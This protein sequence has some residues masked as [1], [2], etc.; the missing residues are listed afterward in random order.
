MTAERPIVLIQPD[1]FEIPSESDWDFSREKNEFPSNEIEIPSESEEKERYAYHFS[2]FTSPLLKGSQDKLV[3][4]RSKTIRK[5][6]SFSPGKAFF[7]AV[8]RYI[9]SYV[10]LCHTPETG[11]WMGGTPEILLSGEKG[12]WQTV[13][14]AG[15]QSLRDG[16]LPKSWDHKNW[17]E[18]QLVASYIRRQLSTLGITPE[19]KGPYSARAGE[20]SHLKSDFFFSLPNPEKLVMS[21][22][23]YT[24]LQPFAVFPRRRLIISSSR[25][26]GT[27]VAITP[28]SSVGWIPKAKQIC[29]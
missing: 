3:L 12:D 8:E 27:I 10:Y 19:E 15:T 26:R 23:Y 22:N 21:F 17:R 29:T 16:K 5:D 14:L 24:L 18:Q 25:M 9:R 4:S 13:A 6:P 11:T 7:A 2:L 20:V 28:V 1:C